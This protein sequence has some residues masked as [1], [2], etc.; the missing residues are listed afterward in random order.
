MQSHFKTPITMFTHKKF[1]LFGMV[2]CASQSTAKCGEA[3]IAAPP[4]P[5]RQNTLPLA[6]T[7]PQHLFTLLASPETGWAGAGRAG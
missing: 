2:R 7:I 3:S 1:S 5:R 6:L 4:N